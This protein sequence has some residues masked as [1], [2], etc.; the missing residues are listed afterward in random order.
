M[1]EKSW[2]D[3]TPT[4]KAKW[5]DDNFNESMS[6]DTK[7]KLMWRK[8]RYKGIPRHRKRRWWHH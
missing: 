1:A 2:N 8:W 7:R 5:L 3:L 4:E 6:E